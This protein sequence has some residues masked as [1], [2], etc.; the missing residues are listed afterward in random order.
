[1][2][3]SKC[4]HVPG[5]DSIIDMVHP[6]TGLSHIQKE[7]LEQIRQRYPGAELR[8]YEDVIWEKAH[9]QD[10]EP[11]EW[12]VSLLRDACRMKLGCNSTSYQE[13][14]YDSWR[15]IW[16]AA[17]SYGH[18][19]CYHSDRLLIRKWPRDKARLVAEFMEAR[20]KRM[21]A[22]SEA[23]PKPQPEPQPEQPADEP[24]AIE[25][26]FPPNPQTETQNE[27]QNMSQQIKMKVGKPCKHS[28]RFETD[29]P[30]APVSNVYVSRAMPGI[31][32]AKEI[33]VTVE[34]AN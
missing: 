7:N 4:F 30:K 19:N 12:L 6:I 34:T 16:D 25:E 22:E 20:Q 15:S 32:S 11:R 29:D 27:R 28:I 26:T 2:T 14:D 23:Q 10:G 9:R 5:S 8:E 3:W 31:E 21:A 13:G 33:T 24:M 1:M 18:S 17:D